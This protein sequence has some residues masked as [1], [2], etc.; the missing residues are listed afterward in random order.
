[1]GLS[2][3]CSGEGVCLKI[4]VHQKQIQSFGW[5][6]KNHTEAQGP[7]QSLFNSPQRCWA[8][9]G[10]TKPWHSAKDYRVSRQCKILFPTVPLKQGDTWV[11]QVTA[12][13]RLERMRSWHIESTL[14]L[15][16]CLHMIGRFWHFRTE[17]VWEKPP[18]D[19]AKY[20]D[21][22]VCK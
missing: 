4:A 5:S 15:N 8:S 10:G 6:F 22:A 13:T 7:C 16:K 14:T 11:L 18:L 2:S 9:E 12:L 1:M 21:Q 3:Q 19:A 17:P 20:H